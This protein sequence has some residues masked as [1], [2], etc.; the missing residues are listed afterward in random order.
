MMSLVDL[1]TVESGATDTLFMLERNEQTCIRLDPTEINL[2]KQDGFYVDIEE[3]GSARRP[4]AAIGDG[5][6]AAAIDLAK[7]G[8]KMMKEAIVDGRA[9]MARATPERLREFSNRVRPIA[10]MLRDSMDKSPSTD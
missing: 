10:Q 3:D 4:S 2:A 9:F 5:D 1:F 7:R 8:L 6:V